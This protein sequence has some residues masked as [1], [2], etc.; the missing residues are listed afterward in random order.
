MRQIDNRIMEIP[1]LLGTQVLKIPDSFKILL[2]IVKVV[3][4]EIFEA[5]SKPHF[6]AW[7]LHPLTHPQGL[8]VKPSSSYFFPVLV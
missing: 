2:V 7:A 3:G 4:Q 1:S 8:T 6:H 5:I